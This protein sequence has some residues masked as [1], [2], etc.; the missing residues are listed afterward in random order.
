MKLPAI[1]VGDHGEQFVKHGLP[2]LCVFSATQA[3][4]SLL[5][6]KWSRAIH[7]NNHNFYVELARVEH[8]STRQLRERIDSILFERSAISRKPEDA[9]SG[10]SSC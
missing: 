5:D 3:R 2:G 7:A 1:E 9:I 10:I 6:G 4:K 8:W